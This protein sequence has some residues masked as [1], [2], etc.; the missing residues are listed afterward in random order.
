M[1]SVT[2]DGCPPLR[3]NSVGFGLLKRLGDRV[4]EVDC[5][6]ELIFYI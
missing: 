2:K 3:E 4:A 6:R 5:T 1:V